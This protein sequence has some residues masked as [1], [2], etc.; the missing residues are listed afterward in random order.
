M[1]IFSA[2]LLFC[3]SI[4]E[5]RGKVLEMGGDPVM[6]VRSRWVIEIGGKKTV[7]RS[8]DLYMK[9][10]ILVTLRKTKEQGKNWYVHYVGPWPDLGPAGDAGQDDGSHPQAGHWLTRF[11]DFIGGDSEVRQPV[12]GIE[13]RCLV[14]AGKGIKTSL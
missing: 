3:D 1:Y 8:R 7:I 6:E 5:L 12:G 2:P 13:G 4:A 14:D 10:G 9:D 11:G